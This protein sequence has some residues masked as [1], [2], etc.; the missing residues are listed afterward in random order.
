MKILIVGRD[1]HHQESIQ[2]FGDTHQYTLLTGHDTLPTHLDTADLIL[3]FIIAEQPANFAVYR[4]TPTPVFLNTV[5]RSLAALAAPRF[6]PGR[7]VGFNGM[8]TLLHRPL[9]ELA[10]WSKEDEPWVNSICEKL[11]TK[12]VL[13]E[14][15]VGLVT[16]RVVCM[17]INEAYYTAMEGTATKES[18]DLAMKLG[19]NYPYGPFEWCARIGIRQ[20][21]E[22]LDAVYADTKDERYKICPLLRQEYLRSE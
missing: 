20:V 8:H 6:H 15:R 2:K 1:Q 7:M 5:T 19:T 16:P 4:K 17:I 9:L 22:L 14:D 13:V 11:Q 18:I 3:D 10:L 21:Y 12:Y